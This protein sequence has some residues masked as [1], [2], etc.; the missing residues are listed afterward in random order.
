[1]KHVVTEYHVSQKEIQR[2]K[3]QLRDINQDITDTTSPT[4][5]LLL[6][7]AGIWIETLKNKILLLNQHFSL[8]V[9][10]TFRNS[11]IEKAHH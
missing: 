6:D 2:G 8:Q 1:M 5:I 7:F 11:T 4:E 3:D 10:D 9:P